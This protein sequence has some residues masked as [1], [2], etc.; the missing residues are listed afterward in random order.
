MFYI[1]DND[2][3]IQK[4][5]DASH[6]EAFVEVITKND[7]I[8][9]K[10]NEI[11]L[12]YYR[13][14]KE[15]KGYIIGLKHQDIF[16]I[17]YSKIVELFEKTPVLFV[18]NKKNLLY[19]PNF[20]NF[21]LIDLSILKNH[22]LNGEIEINY[23][24]LPYYFTNNEIIPLVKHYERCEQTYNEVKSL[25]Q[26][27]SSSDE[28]FEYYNST[29]VEEFQTVECNG[30]KIDKITFDSHFNIKEESHSIDNG[31][32][33]TQYN[34][35]TLT[36]RPA[37][38][39]NNINFS[40]LNKKDGARKSFIP[41][42]DTF[43]EY[44]YDSY[45]LRLLAW[46]INYEFDETS[47]HEQLAKYYFKTDV[48]SEEQYKLS[49]QYSFRQL[50]GG[51]SE[52]YIHVPYFYN[53]NNLTEKLW[54]EFNSNGFIEISHGKRFYKKHIKDINPSKLLNYYIQALETFRNLNKIYQINRYC[55]DLNTK[56][57]LYNYD[58]FVLDVDTTE[59]IEPIFN[60][61]NSK[62]FP[63][64]TKIGKTLNF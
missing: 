53:V 9:P 46:I 19:Y 62:K 2:E 16:S 30:L 50:Y 49:K 40:A 29:F 37:N 3:Q 58:S 5:I 6:S 59:D 13:P 23:P 32:I 42:N 63:V 41:K 1:V 33:F 60:I 55:A 22:Y 35:N 8:H 11:I 56:L 34:L 64:K 24:S 45:H 51:V 26:L 15:K 4:L 44:D 21:N 17:K 48:V 38:S 14:L 27:Y 47:V 20:K 61:L 43:I 31:I 39:Y 54:D 25:F 28:V 12:V 7:N 57:V 36:T 52:Q 18:L 10:I